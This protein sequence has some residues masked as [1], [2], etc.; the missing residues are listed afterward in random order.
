MRAVAPLASAAERTFLIVVS[1]I[2]G[3][4][5]YSEK[6]TEWSRDLVNAARR[7]LEL[8]AEHVVYL[9]ETPDKGADG[10]ARK[11]NI[12][13]AIER[14]ATDASAGDTVFLV[15]IGHGTARGDRLL[16]NLPGPDLG[17]TE[18]DAMLAS[19][20]ELRWVIVNGSPSSGPFIQ[21]LSAP[22]RIVITA[23]TNA[24]E[25]FH[26]VFPE[27]FVAA[28]AGPGADSDKNGRVS[29]LEAFTFAVRG[30]ERSYAEAGTIVS[31]HAVL[32]D[33]GGLA[34]STYLESSRTRFADDI[35]PDELERLLV[36]RDDLEA[37]ISSLIAEKPR[38][39][40]EIYDERLESLLVQFALVHRALR[41]SETK[42]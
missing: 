17:A 3:E 35:P 32:D 4:P 21:A 22:N 30:V 26:T 34:R 1:G 7:R 15:L 29:V 40:S 23:T 16:F 25:R 36:E 41:P 18:L 14:I 37:R 33:A 9:A 12:Q 8:P 27:H 11:E 20:A 24:V 31:E 42:P 6:F 19:H 38:L 13:A 28:Y 2:G 39:D 5:V 10:E